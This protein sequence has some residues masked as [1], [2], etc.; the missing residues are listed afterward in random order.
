MSKQKFGLTV[1]KSEN[2][3]TWYTQVLDK[4]EFLDY[5]DVKGCYIL[6]PNGQFIWSE[7][8]RWFTNE[9]EKIN[10]EEYSFP[11]LIPKA[12]LEKEAS[13][14]SDF[15]P[16]VAWI[17]KCGDEVLHEPVAIRPTSET[18]IYP[19]FAKW[20]SS[21]RDLPLKINQWCNILRWELRGTTPLIRSKEFLW[22]EGHTAHLKKSDADEEVLYVLDLYYRIYKELLAVPVIKGIKTENEKFAGA[23]YSTTVEGF[24]PQVGRGIQAATSHHLG[25]TFSQMFDV[26]AQ[27]DDNSSEFVYQNSW[28][29]TTRSLGIAV[30]IHSDDKGLVLP[31]RVAK[32]Q[33]IIIPCGIKTKTKDEDKK[34]LINVVEKIKRQLLS[35][36][37][38]AQVDSRDNITVGYKYNHWELKGVPLRFTIGPEE[39]EKKEICVYK[40]N[41]GEKSQVQY[42]EDI[43]NITSKL[44]DEIQKELYDKALVEQNSKI[45]YVK[46]FPEFIKFLDNNFLLMTPWCE[47][48]ECEEEIKKRSTKYEDGKILLAG[49]KSL[50]IPFESKE[51]NNETCI[52]CN[53]T[54]K[55]YTLFGRSY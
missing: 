1:K 32:T 27:I 31:P 12:F 8:R 10:V 4:G 17:T 39:L 37:I 19:S 26:K 22:Q 25:Q 13:H 35:A 24:I 28:G 49:A 3:S 48:S 51:F 36:N 20:I 29:F 53:G 7:I 21:H 30:M 6:R 15:S 14:I 46:D 45:K 47:K 11:M 2:F 9:I 16:E 18:V 23:D 34:K 44:L 41:T 5:Y 42:N 43:A 52:I 54:C 33:V 55:R 40:R 50:C 38:R